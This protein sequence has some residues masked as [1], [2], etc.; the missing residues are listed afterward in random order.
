MCVYKGEMGTRET[1]IRSFKSF[2]IIF[3]FVFKNKFDSQRVSR[4]CLQEGFCFQ[5]GILKNVSMSCNRVLSR[6]LKIMITKHCSLFIALTRVLGIT[7]SQGRGGK[8]LCRT[9]SDN[10]MTS[11]V[12][13]RE[14]PSELGS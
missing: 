6:H 3:L 2:W 13:L 1:T 11:Q 5:C 10:R 4:A 8:R 14:A 9:S 7:L 12:C